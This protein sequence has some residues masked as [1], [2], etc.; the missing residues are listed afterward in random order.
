MNDL[1][2]LGFLFEALCLRDLYVYAGAAGLTLHHYLD[3]YNLEAD[4]VLVSPTGD[5]A[6]FE[7]KLGAN[8][9]DSAAKNLLA[10]RKELESAAERSP[11]AL[12]VLVGTGGIAERRS[13]GVLVLPVDHLGR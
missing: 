1:N 4:A 5:W 9:V 7:I 10:L 8:Q 2:T 11:R 6:A 13:D 12:A 3:E